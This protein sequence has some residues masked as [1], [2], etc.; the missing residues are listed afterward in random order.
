MR[1]LPRSIPFV[2]VS[3]ALYFTA[4][5]GIEAVRILSSPVYGLDLPGFAHV[6]YGIGRRFGL[7]AEGLIR[8]A[9]FLGAAKLSVAALFAIYLVSRI[10]SLM[11]HETDHEIVDAAVLLVASITVV[12]A[13]PAL[14]D[15]EAT[16]L[17]EHR[18]P[19]WLGGLA[20]TLSMIERVV[21]DEKASERAAAARQRFTIYD[22]TLPPKRNGVSTLRWDALRRTA[23]VAAGP[24]TI[25]LQQPICLSRPPRAA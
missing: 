6:V 14:I 10:K 1:W 2:I 20:V 21:A 7:E 15:G 19:L 11:G 18:L 9:A 13:M 16:L 3:I 8:L 17:A 23:N 4:H 22:V 25:R 12:A 5:F 24:V